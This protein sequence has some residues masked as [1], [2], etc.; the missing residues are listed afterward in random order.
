MSIEFL[1]SAVWLAIQVVS[2]IGLADIVTGVAHW[3]IDTLGTP[4]TPI[5]GRMFVGPT[6]Y[7][8]HK[9]AHI[10]TVH[11]LSGNKFAITIFGIVAIAVSLAGLFTWQFAIFAAFGAMGQQIH[12]WAHLPN[13]KVPKVVRFAQRVGVLQSAQHHWRHHREPHRS[14][15]CVI[16]PW[17]NPMLEKFGFWR[18]LESALQPLTGTP[19]NGGPVRHASIS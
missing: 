16:T 11:W 13:F 17:L 9:P 2:L 18:K 4:K 15:Y 12:R 19:R 7:H 5:W 3:A 6:D 10:V 8:H 14:H 1:T